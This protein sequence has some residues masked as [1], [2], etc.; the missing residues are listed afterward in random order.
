MFAQA[1]AQ[2]FMDGYFKLAEQFRTQDKPRYC[3]IST[4]TMVLNAL[5]IDPKRVWKA[6]WRWYHE[7][8]LD[9]CCKSLEDVRKHGITFDELVCVAKCN[10]LKVR[11]RRPLFRKEE[12]NGEFALS[13]QNNYQQK[14]I[15][16]PRKR[17]Y[18][19]SR[20]F[21]NNSDSP[22]NSLQRL[23]PS[24]TFEKRH[25]LVL[26]EHFSDPV[27]TECEDREIACPTFQDVFQSVE[28]FRKDILR[29]CRTVEGPVM[30]VSYSRKEFLQT[31]D[32]HF[33]CIGGYHPATD[34]CLILD[35]AR[36]KYPPHWVKVDAL[37]EAMCRVDSDTNATRGWVVFDIPDNADFSPQCFTLYNHCSCA[38]HDS[39]QFDSISN[40]HH[41]NTVYTSCKSHFWIEIQSRNTRKITF[42]Q[43]LIS[44][45]E[46]AVKSGLN[47]LVL[48]NSIS[49][50]QADESRSSR[51]V[52][53]LEQ[54]TSHVN[55]IP[56]QIESY[57]FLNRI[58]ENLPRGSL[59]NLWGKVM[60]IPKRIWWKVLM[61]F[62]TPRNESLKNTSPEII[63]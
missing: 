58:K 34:M 63:S 38:G 54:K 4:L 28:T 15:S 52:P 45:Q 40:L 24:Q 56:I 20:T 39:S 12:T 11:A 29:C 6:P 7:S 43:E 44:L 8:M 59:E 19:H 17:P 37:Y 50:S 26:K 31:G 60:T 51:H 53:S 9:C 2:G 55:T 35:T 46:N 21:H 13:L 1:L 41:S 18:L 42:L 61:I 32:G 14:P 25:A 48:D 10:N 22:E 62:F 5:C 27:L 49:L 57:P 23:S 36:Y 3:G 47:S 33:S 30:A 16:P